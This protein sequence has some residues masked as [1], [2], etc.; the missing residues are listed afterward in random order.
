MRAAFDSYFRHLLRWANA[1]GVATLL[2]VCTPVTA[3]AATATGTLTVQ[4]TISTSCTISAATLNFGSLPGTAVIAGATNASVN[5]SVTCTNGSPYSI[6]MNNGANAS[7]SQ[8]RMTNGASFINY[9]LYTDA[10]RTSPW[11]TATS[12]TTCTSTNSC[13]LGTGNGSAQSVPVYGQ[14]PAVGSAPTAS[15]YTDTVTMTIT[16]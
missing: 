11:T 16:Y 12:S 7:G 5:V 4:M 8:R 1:A 15:T 10:G 3:Q 6:A 2:G 14:V 13:Y 9:N